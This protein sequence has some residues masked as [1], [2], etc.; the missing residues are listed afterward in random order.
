MNDND[1]RQYSQGR[2]KYVRTV[3]QTRFKDGTAGT[4]G[5]PSHYP[6]ESKA[7]IR[8]VPRPARVCVASSC[9]ASSDGQA[10]VGPP[11]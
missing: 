6:F 2:C 1:A 8:I 10:K 11:V 5:G 4:A 9:E 7:S 3:L